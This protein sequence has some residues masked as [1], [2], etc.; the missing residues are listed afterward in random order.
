VLRACHFFAK[1]FFAK[2][3]GMA[4]NALGT[5]LLY[6]LFG[7][8]R[9]PQLV[10]I[11]GML[12]LADLFVPDIIPFVDEVVLGLLALLATQWKVRRQPGEPAPKPPTKNVT[13]EDP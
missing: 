2:I 8:L 5:G 1:I 7:R 3:G 6:R 4:N 11:L 13:P 9:S 12:F 10:A